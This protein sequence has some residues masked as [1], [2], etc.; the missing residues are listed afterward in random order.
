MTLS[1]CLSWMSMKKEKGFKIE[2]SW[3]NMLLNENCR[4][5][6]FHIY[7]RNFLFS[8]SLVEEKLGKYVFEWVSLRKE[9]YR[10]N[11]RKYLSWM[12]MNKEKGF[13]L[14]LIWGKM[15]LNEYGW[16]TRVLDWMQLGKYESWL[17]LSNWA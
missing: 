4:G 8:T 16:G 15:L 7:L 6:R 1:K 17:S 9:T 12:S 14:E 10:L 3:G 5:K 13:K 2:W 11:F